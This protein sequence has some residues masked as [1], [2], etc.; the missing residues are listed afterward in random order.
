MN[1]FVGPIIPA[2]NRA[3]RSPLQ[4]LFGAH[5]SSRRSAELKEPN[6]RYQGVVVLH[7]RDW[8]CDVNCTDS[9]NKR[10]PVAVVVV[11]L[12]PTVHSEHERP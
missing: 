8:I 9:S 5:H 2:Q 12:I 3:L 11:A 7:G 1:Q 4:R 10:A 6:S